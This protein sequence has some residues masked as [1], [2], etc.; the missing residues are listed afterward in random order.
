[1]FNDLDTVYGLKTKTINVQTEQ[2]AI[3]FRLQQNNELGLPRDSVIVAIQCRNQTEEITSSGGMKLVST[4]VFE[5]AYLTL[6]DNDCPGGG[7]IQQLI[8][9]VYMPTFVDQAFFM[10][11][12][13]STLIDWNE[14]FI[15]VNPRVR[16]EVKDLQVFELVIYYLDDCNKPIKP[17]F[18]LRTGTNKAGI[19]K[20]YFEVALNTEATKY[21]L[22][23]SPN[24]GLPQDAIIL[25]FST[26][27]NEKP[28]YGAEGISDEVLD[29]S[30]FTLKKGTWSFVESF[31][32]AL[33]DYKE[34]LF[35]EIDYFPISPMIN[36]EIDW[37]Q[38]HLELKDNTTVT[39]TMVFQFYLI[40]YTK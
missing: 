18:N 31:P 27:Q 6:K 20:A 4:D 33:E 16:A 12:T 8:S 9:Q 17:R 32:S 1:M 35:P 21:A 10:Q 28:L 37:Q 15:Q 39:D 25:G 3:K 2:G 22:S 14:S 40:Y 7:L 29:S 23:N 19:R 5:N 11:P 38:S 30:Y 36:N 34:T 13:P 24:I 26:R